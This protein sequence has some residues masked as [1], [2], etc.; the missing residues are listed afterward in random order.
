MFCCCL[1]A[2]FLCF[3]FL[4]FMFCCFYVLLLFYVLLFCCFCVLFY[5]FVVFMFC[6]C[7]LLVVLFYVVLLFMF[8]FYVFCCFCFVL[9]FVFY[10]LLLFVLPDLLTRRSPRQCVYQKLYWYN[11]F[12]WWRALWCSKHVEDWNKRVRKKNC[13]SSW[14][15]TRINNDISLS[16]CDIIRQYFPMQKHRHLEASR[17]SE[18]EQCLTFF[19]ITLPV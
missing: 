10:V 6:L 14:L 11:W 2:L 17:N 15:F 7:V 19:G 1:Y 3:L 4:F 18:P 16:K 5:V 12:S 9:C 8:C 13:A